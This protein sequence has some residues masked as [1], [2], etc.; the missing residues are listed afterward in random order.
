MGI[1]RGMIKLLMR[2]GK[3]RA[4]SGTVLTCGRQDISATQKQLK[5]WSEEL[6]F[7]LNKVQLHLAENN[8]FKKKGCIS[9]IMFFKSIG[10]DKVD[11]LDFCDFE[12]CTII[13]DLNT[14]IPA[15]LH[16]KYDLIIDSGTSEHIFNFPKVLENYNKMLKIGGRIIHCLPTSNFVNHGF[17]MFSPTV[18]QDYYTSNKWKILDCLF[19]QLFPRNLKKLWKIYEY[20][21]KKMM[22]LGVGGHKGTYGTFFV[23]QKTKKSTFDAQVQQTFYL[24]AWQKSTDIK[25]ENSTT[26]LT[27]KYIKK[28]VS[29]I[30]GKIKDDWRQTY[31]KLISKIHPKFRL[32]CVAKF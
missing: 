29:H 2:E 4:F 11:S 8:H 23:T 9:D 19:I 32:K 25:T 10:L 1:T 17:Y 31:Y 30:P 13:H 6:K 15:R 7:Q 20:N 21:F 5:K 12:K 28:I 26:I 18:F 22:L 27:N 16:N 24:D 3:K 14:N